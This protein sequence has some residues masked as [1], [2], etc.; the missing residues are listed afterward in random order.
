MDDDAKYNLRLIF[1]LTSTQPLQHFLLQLMNRQLVF[2]KTHGNLPP[3]QRLKKPHEYL[4][5]LKYKRH[6]VLNPL[7]RHNNRNTMRG[8]RLIPDLIFLYLRPWKRVHI[9]Q[10]LEWYDRLLHVKRPYYHILLPIH[11]YFLIESF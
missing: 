1:F 2:L 11:E 7:V 6:Q 4:D 9:F 5:R 8:H 3:T 10:I